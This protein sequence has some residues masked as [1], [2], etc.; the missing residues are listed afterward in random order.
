MEFWL[1]NDKSVK[2][3]LQPKEK[4]EKEKKLKYN[5]WYDKEIKT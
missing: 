1:R 5:I 4:S 3:I 2:Q